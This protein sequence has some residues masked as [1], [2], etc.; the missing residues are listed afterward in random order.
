M[1]ATLAASGA[2]AQEVTIANCIFPRGSG[3]DVEIRISQERDIGYWTEG[4]RRVELQVIRNDSGDQI[5]GMSANRLDGSLAMLSLYRPSQPPFERRRDAV[6]T[7]HGATSWGGI[8]E[9][10]LQGVCD[11]E[12]IS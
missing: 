6:L 5:L 7:V 8:E 4:D 9:Q 12:D 3:S 11:V 2:S 10:S 1:L